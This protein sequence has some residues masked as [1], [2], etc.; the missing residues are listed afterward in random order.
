LAA[1]HRLNGQ[2]F[3]CSNSKYETNVQKGHA[4]GTGNASGSVFPHPIVQ[5]G[6]SL[7]LEYVTCKDDGADVFWLMWYD[8]NGDPTIP[9]SGVLNA[10]DIQIVSESLASFIKIA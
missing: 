4:H 10:D 6:Y 7:W 3:T 5:H 8:G 9:L 2:P 1:K